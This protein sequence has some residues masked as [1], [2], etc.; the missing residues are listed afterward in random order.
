MIR[1]TY[2]QLKLL[3]DSFREQGWENTLLL[4]YK[5]GTPRYKLLSEDDGTYTLVFMD[6]KDE[7]TFRLR[8][9]E[10]LGN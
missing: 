3:A 10:C 2:N 6:P 7:M 5:N 4:K 1:I 9:S 8:F